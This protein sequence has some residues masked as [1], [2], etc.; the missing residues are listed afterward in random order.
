MFAGAGLESSDVVR[1]DVPG[2]GESAGSPGRLRVELE[3]LVPALQSGS[4]F[5][6]RSGVMVM[7]AQ[8][9]VA[10]EAAVFIDLLKGRP[11]D[12]VQV[13]LVSFGSVPRNM[14][15]YL[16]EFG[17]VISIRKVNDRDAVAWLRSA[18]RSRRIRLE[19]GAVEALQRR[20]G[21]DIAALEHAL[22][23]LGKVD[24]P[25][26]CQMILDRFRNRPE[27]PTWK[28]TDK[29]WNGAVE[30]ALGLL[31]DYL[32]HGHPLVVVAAFENELRRRA[33]AASAPD[34]ETFAEWAGMAAGAYPTRK[35]WGNRHAM[36]AVNLTKAV[37][38]VRR[39]DATIK[40]MPA[41]T[42]ILTMERLTVA[43]CYWSKS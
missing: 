18:A 7:D 10:D 2:R 32:T 3:P 1:I 5:G 17:D 30:D 9:L 21:A 43:L 33:L 20:F 41:E 23:Q 29:V 40:T 28:L 15:R 25:V 34:L 22:D 35:V 42:H 8:L 38:A 19:G 4:L 13:V 27:Q 24:Q 36:S 11:D 14:A 16:K 6:G 37:D 26:T 12:S 31:H 39:A